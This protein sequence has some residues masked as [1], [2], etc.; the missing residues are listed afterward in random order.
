[1]EMNKFYCLKEVLH[2]NYQSHNLIGPYHFWGISSKNSTSFTRLFRTRRH[3][4]AGHKTNNSPLCH[5]S[6]VCL[7]FTFKEVK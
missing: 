4:Q 6:V 5:A 7:V 3:V 1:M 2:N